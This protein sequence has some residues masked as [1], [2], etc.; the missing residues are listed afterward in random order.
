MPACHSSQIHSTRRVFTAVAVKNSPSTFLSLLSTLP[1]HDMPFPSIF[2]PEIKDLIIDQLR[3]DPQ[4]LWQCALTC[5]GWLR[6]SRYNLLARV[7]V[8]TRK[9]LLT[10]CS[11]IIQYPHLRPLVRSVTLEPERGRPESLYLMDTIPIPLLT[12]L[13]NLTHWNLLGVPIEKPVKVTENT[14]DHGAQ[15]GAVVGTDRDKKSR[16][17]ALPC[18]RL[19]LACLRRHSTTIQALHLTTVSFPTSM[20]CAISLLSFPALRSLW[21]GAIAVDS[22]QIIPDAWVSRVAGR[23]HIR[24]LSVTSRHSTS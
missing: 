1:A 7:R 13:P 23:V 12:L 9:Q 5:S 21:L 8:R 4:T 3:Y 10:L 11:A 6:R 19:A 22:S 20:D 16:Y 2:P 15:E 18:H 14:A 17:S 24:S